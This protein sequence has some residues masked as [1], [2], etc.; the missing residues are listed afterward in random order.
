M[1]VTALGFILPSS[2]LSAVGAL[3][4]GLAGIAFAVSLLVSE[5]QGARRWVNRAAGAAL[6]VG[7]P[8]GVAWSLAILFGVGFLNMDAMVRSHGALNA[9]AVLLATAAYRGQ[10]V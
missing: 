5:S 4:V 3:L 2:L 6:L 8:M 10:T 9:T 1:P 7:V